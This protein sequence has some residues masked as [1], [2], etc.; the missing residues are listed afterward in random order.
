MDNKIIIRRIIAGLIDWNLIF[1]VGICL[2]T[3]GPGFDWEYI[4]YP[5]LQMFKGIP[6]LL[7]L[8]WMLVVPI[9]R[10]CIFGG[11]S[12]G[13]LICGIRVRDAQTGKMPAFSMLL[14]RGVFFWL[15][16]IEGIILLVNN[17]KSLADI[18]TKTVV[19]LRKDK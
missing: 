17:G 8:L 3:A 1:I 15:I 10:D 2:L 6:F 18:I 12:L 16:L 11:A 13:K 7:G 4:I 14:L 9:L 5:S 19:T